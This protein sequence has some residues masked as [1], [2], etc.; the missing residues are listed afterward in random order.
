MTIKRLTSANIT[1]SNENGETVVVT[2]QT[3]TN[4]DPAATMTLPPFSMTVLLQDVT[5]S[6]ALR[7]GDVNANG[8]V[9]AFD[10]SMALQAVVGSTTLSPQQQCAADYNGNGAVTAFDA[11]LI[12]QCVVGSTCSSGTCP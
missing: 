9:T 3:A 12:L 7:K 5:Q 8:S 6:G 4:F 10:A 1:D 2:T 11:S